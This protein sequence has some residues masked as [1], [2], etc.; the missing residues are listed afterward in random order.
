MLS[1]GVWVPED[2]DSCHKT[3][4]IDRVIRIQRYVILHSP[5]C[6]VPVITVR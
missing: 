4:K 2:G 5:S 1:N 3:G 6:K